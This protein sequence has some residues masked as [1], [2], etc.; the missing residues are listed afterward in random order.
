MD[1]APLL[2]ASLT[3]SRNLMFERPNSPNAPVE[4]LLRKNRQLNLNL[5]PSPSFFGSAF[6]FHLSLILLTFIGGGAVASEVE[7]VAITKQAG[8]HFKHHDGRSGDRYFIEPLGAGAAFL[9][10]DNDGFQDIYFVNGADLPGTTSE[11]LPQNALYRNKGDGT[12]IDVTEAA[13]VGDTGYGIGCAVGDYDNDGFR[14]LYVT[15]FGANVFYHN[16]G[17]GTFTN[18]TAQTGTGDARWGTSCAFADYD[19]DGFLDL[20]VT[21]YVKYTIASDQVCTNKGVRVY[22]DPRIYAGERDILYHNNGDGT[23]TDV[24][25]AAGFSTATGRGLAA[26]F[27]D[28]D[29]DGDVDLYI[30]ND[31]D[32]NFL[33]RNNGDG[34]FTDVSLIAGVG[35]SEDGE[36]ENGMGVDFGDYNNDGRLDLIVTN[37]QGQTNTLYRNDGGGLFSDLSYASGLGAI[38]L[39]YLAWGANFFDY[40]S[41]GYQDLFI[42]N[43][44]LHD[45]V[46]AFDPLGFYE[47]PNLLFRNC[48]DGTFDEVGAHAGQGLD[49]E[50]V[51]RGVAFADYD[52]DGDLDLLVTNLN[53]APDLL[54]NNGGNQGTW[55]TLRLVGTRSNRDAIGARVTVKTQNITQIR[56]IRSGSSYLSQSD[57]RLHFGLGG[58]QQADRIEIRW[59][60]GLKERLDGVQANQAI[61]LVEGQVER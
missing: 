3:P 58:Y 51:S 56:E 12:F 60:S 14:D 40:D 50:K 41:D 52:N 48:R 45:N 30:A 8:I 37:F 49:L 4:I 54:Q 53:D 19:N 15:N 42:A 46:Q 55:L 39:P 31:A 9:D 26:A 57:M 36:A 25:K 16:N 23:F 29:D 61:T 21:N 11:V 33:Y 6:L 59:P 34:T 22:C 35:L 10:Y 18:V 2:I 43:G 38:S 44:H 28:Y 17:D 24:T 47:Q 20:Y 13:G 27:G 32:P 7:F 5:L 1:G